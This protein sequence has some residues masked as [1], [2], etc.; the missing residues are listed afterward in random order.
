MTDVE[1]I[2]SKLDIV[3]FIGQ[4]VTLK[5]AGSN[6]KAPCPFHQE[7]TPSFM[8]SHDKQIFKCFGCSR[9]GDVITF[10]MEQEK[11]EFRE[12]L[13]ILADK[14]GVQLEKSK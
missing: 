1:A 5:K 7:K 2:K 6:Y 9:G 8:V 12:A 10:L 4:Y 3:E 11:L 13:Q 14:V